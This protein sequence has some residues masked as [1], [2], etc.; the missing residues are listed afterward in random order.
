MDDQ[1]LTW[2]LLH[3]TL[4]STWW[5]RRAIPAQC[6]HTYH[7]IHHNRRTSAPPHRLRDCAAA[8]LHLAR[9]TELA[10]RWHW[11]VYRESLFDGRLDK[12]SIHPTISVF[13]ERWSV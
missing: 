3:S 8:H 6:T 7:S 5:D 4:N 12:R 13:W 11:T 2:T 10:R 1:R 9:L